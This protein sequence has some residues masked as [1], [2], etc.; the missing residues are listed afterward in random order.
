MPA[1]V[2]AWFETDGTTAAGVDTYTP[3]AGTPTAAQ[4]TRIYNDNGGAAAADDA[5]EL[6]ITALARTS[7]GVNFTAEHALAAGAYI[8]CRAVGSGGTGVGAQTT[9]WTPVG[10]GKFLYLRDLPSDC[11]RTIETRI[12]APA[13]FGTEDVEVL[14]RAVAN[15][16]AVVIEDGHHESGAVGVCHGVGDGRFGALLEG[17]TL[18]ATGS[19][20]D[21]VNLD[22]TTWIAA[23]VPWTLVPQAITLSANDSAAAALA[24]GESY[25]CA[26]TLASDG[27]VTQTKSVKGTSPLAVSARPTPP[28]DEPLL[29]YVER[30]FDATIESG[31]IY[32]DERV[33]GWFKAESSGASLVVTISAGQAMVDN[34]LIIFNSTSNVTCTA[35]DV[36]YVYLN[37]SGTFTA[38]ITGIR[39][40]D[41]SLLLYE[42][43]C[44]GTGVTATTDRRKFI[45]N[46]LIT[47]TFEDS[48]ALAGPMYSSWP[49]GSKGYVLPLFGVV[50]SLGVPGTVSGSTIADINKADAG[51]FAT[52]FTSQGTSD[53]RPQ[54]AFGT[55]NYTDTGARPEV[56]DIGPWSRWRVDWMPRPALLGLTE[57]C[58]SSASKWILE[59]DTPQPIPSRKIEQTQGDSDHA[60]PAPQDLRRCRNPRRVRSF[61]R[62]SGDREDDDRGDH[63]GVPDRAELRARDRCDER[64]DSRGRWR[65][66]C[67]LGDVRFGF[68]GHR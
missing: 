50:L 51:S 46:R 65:Q 35:S 10:K 32:Q 28:S 6:R 34:R 57:R 41:R 13:G 8:E 45:G 37:P 66:R 24:S 25:W 19:P 23:G 29:G 30:E 3:T 21:D 55:G 61:G 38:N 52:I 20:D 62:R 33:Y 47:M 60:I 2:L 1:A 49:S 31:D 63:A 17:G 12:N 56:Y 53:Q 14:L 39:P 26:L 16:P 4:T 22:L 64:H 59:S 40:T 7:G 54:L 18:T 58:M 42:F 67:R 27:T 48:G 36:T 15:S 9:E 5:P 68:V 43:T 11:Y 44:D